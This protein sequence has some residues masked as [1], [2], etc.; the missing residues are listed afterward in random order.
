MSIKCSPPTPS[1]FGVGSTSV[2]CMVTDSQQRADSCTFTVTVTPAP[3]PRLSVTTLVAFGDSMTEGSNVLLPQ[4]VPIPPGS[5]PGDLSAMLT[6]RYTTQTFTVLDEGVPGE[7]VDNG[8]LRLPRVLSVDRPGALLLL[9]GVNDLNGSG[10]S[11]IP[12]VASSLQ[13]MVR[14]ARASGA[15]VFWATLPPQRPGGSRAYA[16]TLIEPLNQ[17]IRALAPTEGAVLVDLYR[18]FNGEVDQLLQSD[19]LHPN[20]AGYMRMAQSFFT[21]IRGRLEVVTQAPAIVTNG[22]AAD[23]S[24]WAVAAARRGANVR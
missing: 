1:S 11:V 14:A 15:V 24:A 22:S 13:G 19:G 20:A 3:I 16:P 9:E 10:A 5:Y 18:D 23:R 21:A 12:S 17:R 4:A 6:A 2:K 8:R 7:T